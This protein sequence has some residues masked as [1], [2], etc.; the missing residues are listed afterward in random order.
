MEPGSDFSSDL[1]RLRHHLPEVRTFWGVVRIL[2]MPVLLFLLVDQLFLM[3]DVFR[4]LWM[5]DAEVLALAVGFL[6]L[7]LFFGLRAPLIERYG[8]QAYARGFKRFIAPGL[9]ILVAV[10]VRIRFIGGPM[11]PERLLDPVGRI[12]GWVFILVGVLLWLRSVL[13]LG[14][15]SLTMT[16]VYFPDEGRRTESAIYTILRHPVYGAALRIALGLALLNGSW[17]ALTLALILGIFLW[18]WV[19]LVEEKE[20]IARFGPAYEEYRRKTPAF[21]PRLR[22]LGK[23]MGFLILG[24]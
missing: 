19:R 15:D 3:S 12:L 11:I 6:C 2:A 13:V 7:Y 9:A 24:R 17:F 16:Y 1:E 21:W 4:G 23:F 22:D 10:I 8:D 5:L 20:L 14:I 18:G